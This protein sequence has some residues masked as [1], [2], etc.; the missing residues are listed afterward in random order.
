VTGP[1]YDDHVTL[2]GEGSARIT[3]FAGEDVILLNIGTDTVLSGAGDDSITADDGR[4]DHVNCGSGTDVVVADPTDTLL[5]C[6]QVTVN[7]RFV[8]TNGD[9]TIVGTPEDD[10]IETGLGSDTVSA[11]AGDDTIF[12]ALDSQPNAISCGAGVDTVFASSL[13]TFPEAD[14]EHISR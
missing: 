5:G 7:R 1:R 13:D 11:L 9:D 6:E 12:S 10:V 3:T 14:C 8:G 2:H 4:H